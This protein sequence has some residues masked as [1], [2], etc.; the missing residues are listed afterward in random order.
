MKKS[1][2]CQTLDSNHVSKAVESTA[3][4][5]L[6]EIANDPSRSKSKKLIKPRFGCESY[7][8]H[9]Y[10]NRSDIELLFALRT[11]MV[12]LKKNFPS[13]YKDDIACRICKVQVECQEHLLACHELRK[14]VDIPDDVKYEDLFGEPE[15]QLKM[16]KIYKKLLRKREVLLSE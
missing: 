14:Y 5:T 2:K 4:I 6:N 1:H 3:L 13:W 16:M 9:K 7:F 10:F 15:K 8:F 11:R 12:N